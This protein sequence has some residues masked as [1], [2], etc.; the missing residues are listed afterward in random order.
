MAKRKKYELD[1]APDVQARIEEIAA[2]LDEFAH[3]DASRV[4]CFRSRH[5]TARIYARIWGLDRIWQIAL[6]V[7]AHY[8]VEVVELFDRSP[9]D[10]QDKTLIHELMHIPKTFSGALV[11]H[12]C[13]GKRIDCEAEDE[14]YRKLEDV[15]AARARTA[16]ERALEAVGVA[17]EEAP[18]GAS[19]ARERPERPL[20]AWGRWAGNS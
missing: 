14:L 17:V 18:A 20:D 5:S 15:R 11:P 4:V 19:A 6:G 10:V 9:R 8:A 2:A 3:V 7:D 1:V 13:F 16:A 12:R